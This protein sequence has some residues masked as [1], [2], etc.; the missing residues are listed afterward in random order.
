MFPVFLSASLTCGAALLVTT[1]LSEGAFLALRTAAE[2]IG[3]VFVLAAVA[4][5]AVLPNPVR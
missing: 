4:G 5:L 2:I 1:N 3:W